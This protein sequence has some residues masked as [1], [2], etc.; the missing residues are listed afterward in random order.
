MIHVTTEDTAAA[1]ANTANDTLSQLTYQH[2]SI[3]M[4]A[5]AVHGK[6]TYNLPLNCDCSCGKPELMILI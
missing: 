4:L 2:G 5:N 3:P 6:P 1:T